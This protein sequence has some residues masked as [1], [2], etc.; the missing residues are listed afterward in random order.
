M[1]PIAHPPPLQYNGPRDFTPLLKRTAVL[2]LHLRQEAVRPHHECIVMRGTADPLFGWR[3]ENAITS[4]HEKAIER[5]SWSMIEFDDRTWFLSP[6]LKVAG[7]E[8]MPV[9]KLEGIV[10]TRR[11]YFGRI[12]HA[13]ALC[14]SAGTS[15]A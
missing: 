9:V 10:N 7:G 1:F 12:S 14:D 15:L 6:G 5:S 2:T 4:K 13:A 3:R 11:Y 8:R